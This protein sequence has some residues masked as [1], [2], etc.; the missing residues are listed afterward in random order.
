MVGSSDSLSDE[1]DDQENSEEED[2][3]SLAEIIESQSENFAPESNEKMLQSFLHHG[4]IG[5][6]DGYG[7]A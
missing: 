7:T 1:D 3:S 6:I 2:R 4:V 5:T